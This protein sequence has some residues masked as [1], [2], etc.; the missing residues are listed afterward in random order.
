MSNSTTQPAPTLE[1]VEAAL[2][3]LDSHTASILRRHL[4]LAPV[5]PEPPPAEPPAA[6]PLD[7]DPAARAIDLEALQRLDAEI[8]EKTKKLSCKKLIHLQALS[9][10]YLQHGQANYVFSG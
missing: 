2:A 7:L 4:G 6:P 8:E 9:N 5:A 1:G 3:K 10:R